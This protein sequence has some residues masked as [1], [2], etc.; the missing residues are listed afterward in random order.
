MALNERTSAQVATYASE[1][2]TM[3]KPSGI[4][5]ELWDKIKSVAAS[6]LTQAP[7]RKVVPDFWRGV[8][9]GALGIDVQAAAA[10]AML[11]LKK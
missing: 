9:I 7:D 6:A 4:T 11:E 5:E 8:N 3:S 10:L 1:I 2:M